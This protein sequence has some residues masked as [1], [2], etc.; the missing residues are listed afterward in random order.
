M[1]IISGNL[2]RTKQTINIWSSSEFFCSAQEQEYR[3]GSTHIPHVIDQNSNKDY[4]YISPI[5]GLKELIS[6]KAVVRQEYR[7]IQ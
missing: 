3:L 5:F 6:A 4:I 7:P 2:R 1:P